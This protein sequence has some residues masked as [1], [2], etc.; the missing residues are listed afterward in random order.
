MKL[1]IILILSF[2]F[3]L[4]MTSCKSSKESQVQDSTKNL[5]TVEKEQNMIKDGFTK[6]T[7]VYSKEPGDCEWTIKLDNGVHYES[8]TLPEEY[9]KADITVYFKFI[10]QRRPNKCAKANPVEITEMITL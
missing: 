1:P 6:G 10:P 4:S 7:I 5:V 2:S 3:T 8:M 9:K